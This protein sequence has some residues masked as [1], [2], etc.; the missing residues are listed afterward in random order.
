MM[1]QY[2]R[3]TKI[4]STTTTWFALLFYSSA[5][6]QGSETLLN[7]YFKEIRTGQTAPIPKPLTLN[8][9]ATATLNAI[10]P[11]YKDTLT[12]VRAKA[13]TI[14]HLAGTNARTEA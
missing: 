13:Y 3:N 6:A 2:L 8:E 10:T 5:F 9:N 12:I 11:Y 14:T 1:N 7:S 4:I